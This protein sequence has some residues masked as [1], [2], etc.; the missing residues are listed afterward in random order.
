MH[1]FLHFF[2]YRHKWKDVFLLCSDSLCALE[3]SLTVPP[4]LPAGTPLW[5][6]LRES[7]RH[8]PRRLPTPSQVASEW[9][10]EKSR[11][12]LRRFLL[13]RFTERPPNLS[14]AYSENHVESTG[15]AHISEN[16]GVPTQNNLLTFFC[17]QMQWFLFFCRKLYY[18]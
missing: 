12:F 5:H 6:G 2:Q 16:K 18:S 15:I 14:E 8:Q 10:E 3:V 11:A 9:L 1:F 4:L 17:Y 13:M 7:A